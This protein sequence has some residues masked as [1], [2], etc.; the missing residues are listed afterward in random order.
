M[1]WR[2]RWRQTNAWSPLGMWKLGLRSF[3]LRMPEEHNRRLT[4][5]ISE[6]LVCANRERKS[7]SDKRECLG[8]NLPHRQHSHRRR[9]PAFANRRK[10]INDNAKDS[11][12]NV[13]FGNCAP[14]RKR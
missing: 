1:F 14:S 11:V 10:K 7:K 5:H 12:Q 3:D 13:R 6:L 9:Q 8:Q 2:R 4:D